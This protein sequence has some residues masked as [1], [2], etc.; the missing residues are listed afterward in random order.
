V[1]GFAEDLDRARE[2]VLDRKGRKGEGFIGG[3]SG[4]GS[5][6]A[7]I[8]ELLDESP[9][10]KGCEEGESRPELGIESVLFR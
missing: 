1:I 7:A 9:P 2:P 8:D 10:D 4:D 5:G 3:G 6:E